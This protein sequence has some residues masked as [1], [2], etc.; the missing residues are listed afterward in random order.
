MKLCFTVNVLQE[1]IQMCCRL[2]IGMCYEKHNI[3]HR[4]TVFSFC[5]IHSYSSAG[6]IRIRPVYRLGKYLEVE[7]ELYSLYLLGLTTVVQEKIE[8]ISSLVDVKYDYD[9]WNEFYY[10]EFGVWKFLSRRYQGL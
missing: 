1:N 2:T 4:L 6:V 3:H 5:E 8:V 9:R 7:I 10:N